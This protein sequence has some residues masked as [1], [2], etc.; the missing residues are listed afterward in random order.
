V[1]GQTPVT[2]VTIEVGE[3][4][5]IVRKKGFMPF[6]QRVT[7]VSGGT[8]SVT[9]AL[10]KE[11]VPVV[12]VE[13]EN[14]KRILHPAIFYSAVGLLAVTS[15]TALATG[16]QAVNA[17]KQ[18]G[19]MYD[20]EPWDKWSERRDRLALTADVMIGLAAVFAAASLTLSFFTRF[21]KPKKEHRSFLAP[22][23]APGG[24]GIRWGV[25]F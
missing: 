11:D 24:G 25:S 20:D 15:I 8:K 3:H 14:T 9:A 12:T 17:D 2:S 6:Y 7:V 21:K 5:V 4:E 16:V 22:E 10:V 18:I 13:K 1:V 23:L 19:S